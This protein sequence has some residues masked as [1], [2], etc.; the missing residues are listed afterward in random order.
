MSVVGPRPLLVRYLPL[1]NEYQARR[2]ALYFQKA[3]SYKNIDASVDEY[4][5]DIVGNVI[6]KLEG[7]NALISE[8]YGQL[9]KELANPDTEGRINDTK[10][11][12]YMLLGEVEL[13]SETVPIKFISMQSPMM[14]MKNK[15]WFK[16]ERNAFREI[17]EPILNLKKSI[18]I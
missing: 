13:G 17:D 6:Y 10:F 7:E 4:T 9:R 14:N 8:A 12:A 3:K 1:Y 11:N 18:D 16:I 2:H 5:G 15:F